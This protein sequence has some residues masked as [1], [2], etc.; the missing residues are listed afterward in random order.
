MKKTSKTIE[1]AR[2]RL[3]GLKSIDPALDL[4]NGVSVANFEAKIEQ[5]DTSLENYNTS[6]STADAN[7]N[8]FE[9]DEKDL[10]EFHERAL[11]AVAAKY[12]KDSI[13]YEKAGGTRKSER[14]SPSKKKTGSEA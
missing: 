6:L 13:E 9:T 7:Q 12:G 3:A 11:L 8:I 4:G 5:T 2:V 1:A 14:R 10:K